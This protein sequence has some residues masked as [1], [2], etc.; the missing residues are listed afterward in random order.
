M[1]ILNG[2]AQFGPYDKV[3]SVV[4]EILEGCF[5]IEASPNNI[6]DHKAIALETTTKILAITTSNNVENSNKALLSTLF[7]AKNA[8]HIHKDETLLT[9]V[10]SDKTTEDMDVEKFEKLVLEVRTVAI[11]RPTNL[12]KF[13][14]THYK[15]SIEFVMKLAKWFWHLLENCPVN[16]SV[17]T[18]G[19]PG[20]THI[21]STVQALIEVFHAFTTI[22]SETIPHVSDL[23]AQFLIADNLQVTSND[24]FYLTKVHSF[25]KQCLHDL[26]LTKKTG[27]F[28][29]PFNC[30]RNEWTLVF[31]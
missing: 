31:L 10:A 3:V 27:T 19:Q 1:S 30:L 12:T 29:K 17:G 18:L 4:L 5:T 8:Y 28:S 24:I 7:P 26:W 23:Y 14:E 22:D 6:E 25:L 16:F 2:T 20:L 13:A 11:S 9:E 21:D 15:S